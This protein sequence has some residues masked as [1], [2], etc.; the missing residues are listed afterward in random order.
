M[1]FLA[2]RIVCTAIAAASIV[3]DCHNET[4]ASMANYRGYL[5]IVIDPFKVLAIVA[6]WIL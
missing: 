6:F 5:N 4:V 1:N 2:F 3:I